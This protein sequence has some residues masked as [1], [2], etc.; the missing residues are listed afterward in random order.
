M[1]V[2]DNVYIVYRTKTLIILTQFFKGKLHDCNFKMAI[3]NSKR[4][5]KNKERIK[6]GNIN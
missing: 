5:E 6:K 1:A 3:K 2:K 4:L